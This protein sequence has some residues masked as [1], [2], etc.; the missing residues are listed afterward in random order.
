VQAPRQRATV[1]PRFFVNPTHIK[2]KLG[3]L[4][5]RALDRLT[6]TKLIAN[7]FHFD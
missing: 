2:E 5:I 4:S 6:E 3:M 1:A 7:H